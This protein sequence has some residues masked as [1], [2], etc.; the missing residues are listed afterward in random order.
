MLCFSLLT[1][2]Y[3]ACLFFAMCITYRNKPKDNVSNDNTIPY[4]CKYLKTAGL[5][6]ISD[7]DNKSYIQQALWVDVH[8]RRMPNGWWKNLAFWNSPMAPEVSLFKSKSWS[9]VWSADSSWM[10][11]SFLTLSTRFPTCTLEFRC[12]PTLDIS[13]RREARHCAQDTRVLITRSSHPY[14]NPWQGNTDVM[15]QLTIV[16]I[17]CTHSC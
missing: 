14:R 9:E 3:Y 16:L 10:V 17:T 11:R 2:T 15:G 6:Y 13:S 4:L 5:T 7:S 1:E 12:A 8:R